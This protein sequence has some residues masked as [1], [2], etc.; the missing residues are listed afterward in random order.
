[1]WFITNSLFKLVFKFAKH[2]PAADRVVF[3]IAKVF[4]AGCRA[5]YI[6]AGFLSKK[7]LQFCALLQIIQANKALKQLRFR[8]FFK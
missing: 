3:T 6:F 8:S 2:T 7:N 4:Q 1:M 5:K